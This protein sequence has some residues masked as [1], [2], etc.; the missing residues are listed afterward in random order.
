MGLPLR[1]AVFR[2]FMRDK[3]VFSPC[4]SYGVIREEDGNRSVFDLFAAF[5]PS[6][7][8]Q[9]LHLSVIAWWE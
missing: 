1:R 7:I 6:E 8:E 5:Q 2:N 9:S 3:G 4:F